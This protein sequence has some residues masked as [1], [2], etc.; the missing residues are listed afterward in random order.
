M[1]KNYEW[2]IETDVSVRILDAMLTNC[3]D[4]KNMQFLNLILELLLFYETHITVSE[5]NI[6]AHSGSG[7]SFDRRNWGPGLGSRAPS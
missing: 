6:R 2:R 5:G 3:Y 4:S 1:A 7:V